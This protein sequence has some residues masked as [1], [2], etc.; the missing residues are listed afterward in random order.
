MTLLQR[1]LQI[2][3][4]WDPLEPL[5]P[6]W[7]KCFFRTKPADEWTTFISRSC[8]KFHSYAAFWRFS[9]FSKATSHW[10]NSCTTVQ[11]QKTQRLDRFRQILHIVHSDIC[12][13]PPSESITNHKCLPDR[14]TANR[15][16]RPIIS[17]KSMRGARR[18]E[19]CNVWR[20]EPK[21]ENQIIP[22][23]SMYGIVMV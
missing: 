9:D 20:N 18:T 5:K 23:G 4:A 10:K 12:T 21:G 7:E 6:W 22:I 17:N 19:T 11:L 14:W 3:L 15:S 1:K 16:V 8:G 13:K 2:V